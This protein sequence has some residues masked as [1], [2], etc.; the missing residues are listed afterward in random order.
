MNLTTCLWFDQN[1]RQAAN[2]YVGIFPDS[3]IEDAWVTQSGTP[4]NKPGD[5]V[6]VHFK[7]FGQPFVGLNGGPRFT[8][9]EAVSFQIP[10]KDQAEIDKYWALLTADGGQESMCGWLKDKFG[11]SWQVVPERLSSYLQG[12]DTAGAKRATEA[13]LKMKKIDLAAIKAAYEGGG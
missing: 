5:E 6:L 11:V 12:A 9:S 3:S 13:L 8:H 2:F 4:G 10:C 7:I 1:A